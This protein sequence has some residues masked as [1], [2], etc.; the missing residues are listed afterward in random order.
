M[1]QNA[2]N[3]RT[4]AQFFSA[5]FARKLLVIFLLSRLYLRGDE[6]LAGTTPFSFKEFLILM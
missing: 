5:R 6:G 1:A 4:A 2:T 3:L